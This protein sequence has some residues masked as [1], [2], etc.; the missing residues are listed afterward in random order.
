MEL[1]P[2]YELSTTTNVDENHNILVYQNN[3][4][5][6]MKSENLFHTKDYIDKNII[7]K[8]NDIIEALASLHVNLEED[9]SFSDIINAMN[10]IDLFEIGRR[11][12]VHNG[13]STETKYDG[14][15]TISTNPKYKNSGIPQ[16]SPYLDRV[17][18]IGDLTTIIPMTSPANRDP[19]TDF[20]FADWSTAAGLKRNDFIGGVHDTTG[21]WT[22]GIY[23]WNKMKKVQIL[24]NAENPTPV[25]NYDL[26]VDNGG[27]Y[28]TEVPL[29]FIKEEIKTEDGIDITDSWPIVPVQYQNKNVYEYVFVCKSK[30]SG[31]RP[32]EFFKSYKNN[33][34]MAESVTGKYI[35]LQDLDCYYEADTFNPKEK[36]YDIAS[37]ESVS[38]YIKF[39]DKKHYF[40]C[41]EASTYVDSDGKTKFQSRPSTFY[42]KILGKVNVNMANSRT[43]ARNI[44]KSYQLQD[45]RS[46][47]DFFGVLSEIEF[48]SLNCQ[49]SVSGVTSLP[50]SSSC[51]IAEAATDTNTVK[52]SISSFRVGQTICIGSSL[53]SSQ[54]ATDRFITNIRS[55][56]GYYNI[57]FT[58]NPVTVTTSSV[59][60]STRYICGYTDTDFPYNYTET[61]DGLY[62]LENNKYVLAEENYSGTRYS[63][64]YTCGG[65]EYRTGVANGLSSGVGGS[66]YPIKWNWIENPWG[67][68]WKYIDGTKVRFDVDKN[69]LLEN[70][71][72]TCDNPNLYTSNNND[73]ETTYEKIPYIAP[74][75]F[76][77]NSTRKSSKGYVTQLG[78][79]PKHPWLRLPSKTESI[80]S[81]AYAYSDYFYQNIE[82][83]TV[84]ATR[85]LLCAGYWGSGY[86]AGLRCFCLVY[87]LS[88]SNGHCGASFERNDK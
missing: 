4:Y 44:N 28:F 84:N 65:Y 20:L 61:A 10:D 81:N 47:Q 39:L 66:T 40:A 6:K 26:S 27:S 1:K 85:M 14:G 36:R 88:A 13:T 35:Y 3:E 60:W 24:E 67:N 52:V 5:K 77:L 69:G 68:T 59:L 25:V 55:E 49:F 54:I 56:S 63:P 16:T 18:R 80:S 31:Y 82:T 21:R 9:A 12:L 45:M 78:R 33:I 71:I 62:K 22:N 19:N 83:G 87:G 37:D 72:Y 58:G 11:R 8:K 32:A 70:S 75:E 73:Y 53:N 34:V 29:Y 48:A 64:E 76:L 46:H 42:N 15:T 74:S 50:Y 7:S 30:L 86:A 38:D 43:Y 23:P 79:D 41:Y 17:Y 51:T 57:T 2:F